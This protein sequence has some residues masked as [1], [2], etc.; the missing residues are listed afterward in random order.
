MLTLFNRGKK[1]K[2]T[3]TRKDT[4]RLAIL[5]SETHNKMSEQEK[6]ANFLKAEMAPIDKKFLFFSPGNEYKVHNKK[7][8][9]SV[10]ATSDSYFKLDFPEK[11]NRE[12][13][14]ITLFCPLWIPA[15][16]NSNSLMTI[17]LKDSAYVDPSKQ[18]TLLGSFP[19]S[20]VTSIVWRMSHHIAV[21][22]SDQLSLHINIED[23]DVINTVMGTLKLAY[24]VRYADEC[25]PEEPIDPGMTIFS[26]HK[27]KDYSEN[28][29]G[30]IIDEL[31]DL[32]DSKT[33]DFAQSFKKVIDRIGNNVHQYE[34]DT[35]KYV[36]KKGNNGSNI[37]VKTVE[38]PFESHLKKYLT[39]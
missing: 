21:S 2:E 19:V 25:L 29:T 37:K 26:Y 30:L 7:I 20:K 39:E 16:I 15:R 18:R 33:S 3:Q 5:D 12:Y 17:Y 11:V 32:Y 13:F 34:V 4:N 10:E 6:M 1:T 27:G 9:L 36:G 23:L 35:N 8:S 14:Q 31:I 24:V 22:D 28:V 38:L